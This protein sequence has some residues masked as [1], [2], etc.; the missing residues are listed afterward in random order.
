M[1]RRQIAG[2]R[3][4]ECAYYFLK[5]VPLGVS[6]PVSSVGVREAVIPTPYRIAPQRLA[7]TLATIQRACRMADVTLR[8][9]ECFNVGRVSWPVRAVFQPVSDGPGDPSYKTSQ[10]L[11]ANR[12]HADS[13][14][15]LSGCH[16]AH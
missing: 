4:M 13:M 14:P 5:S 10:P 9:C 3:H 7:T 8:G 11:P 6:P 15:S 1:C 16:P 2:K 12:S